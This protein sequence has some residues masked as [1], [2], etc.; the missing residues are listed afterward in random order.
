MD[1]GIKYWPKFVKVKGAED[2]SKQGQ[3][4]KKKFIWYQTDIKKSFIPW[5]KSYDL[6]KTYQE[7]RNKRHAPRPHYSPEQHLPNIN[8]FDQNVQFY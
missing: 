7:Y 3:G 4:Y 8:K 6:P 5:W 1:T 2:L